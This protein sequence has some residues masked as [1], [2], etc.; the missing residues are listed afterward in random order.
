MQLAGD[1]EE[2]FV[3]GGGGLAVAEHGDD[4]DMVRSEAVARGLG[5]G[6]RR[7][8]AAAVAGRDQDHAAGG[9]RVDGSVR[10]LQVVQRCA[11]GEGEGWDGVVLDS[12]GIVLG[13]GWHFGLV[14]RHAGWVDGRVG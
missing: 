11:G 4:D 7:V 10:D 9:G 14:V 13:G 12:G 1:G 8:D 6:E 5:E 3:G 2:G